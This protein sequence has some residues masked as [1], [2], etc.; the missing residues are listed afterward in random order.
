MSS[1]TPQL[2]AT[3]AQRVRFLREQRMLSLEH[4][5]HHARISLRQLE[6]IEAG[7]EMFLSPSVRQRLARV[8][9]VRPQRLKD[10]EQPP[11]PSREEM[12]GIAYRQAK[13]AELLEAIR[14]N[15]AEA[16]RCP[17][18]AAAL[19][20]RVFERR[21]LHDQPFSVIKAHCSQCLFRLTDD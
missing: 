5:A 15:P 20:I 1:P 14:E 13:G 12:S 17:D 19:V 9:R 4:V 8:L 18:C 6:D 10:V 3:L 2:P 16:Y 21:D 7:I 11:Q